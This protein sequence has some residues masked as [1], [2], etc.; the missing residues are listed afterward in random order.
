[1]PNGVTVV[2]AGSYVFR[3]EQGTWQPFISY[4]RFG[5]FAEMEEIGAVVMVL[6]GADEETL[7]QRRLADPYLQLRSRPTGLPGIRQEIRRNREVFEEY[8]YI[9]ERSNGYFREPYNLAVLAPNYRLVDLDQTVGKILHSVTL[10]ERI[11]DL[12]CLRLV[13]APQANQQLEVAVPA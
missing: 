11:N 1:M 4:E 6:L 9:L 12:G 3:N 8:M 2:D 10:I 13:D 7:Q 5:Q